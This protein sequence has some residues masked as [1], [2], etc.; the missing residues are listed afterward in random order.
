MGEILGLK[1]IK[2]PIPAG[3]IQTSNASVAIRFNRDFLI[4]QEGAHL[5]LSGISGLATSML[6]P[7]EVKVSRT[8]LRGLGT[9][10]SPR[11][12]DTPKACAFFSLAIS[13]QN[14]SFTKSSLAFGADDQHVMCS[15]KRVKR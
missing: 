15:K 9:G 7:Y 11:L 2:N 6:E 12:P 14:V 10:N 3:F 4:G 5:N 8:V 1:N 13:E